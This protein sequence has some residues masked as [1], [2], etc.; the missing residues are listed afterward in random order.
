MNLFI[1]LFIIFSLPLFSAI[2]PSGQWSYRKAS[3]KNY[4]GQQDRVKITRSRVGIKSSF[5]A[6]KY[7]VINDSNVKITSQRELLKEKKT[8]ELIAQLKSLIARRGQQRQVGELKMRLAELY[9]EQAELVAAREGNQWNK[10]ILSWEKLSPQQRARYPRPKLSTPQAD[11]L[12]Q[13]SLVLYT[14]LEANS[15]GRDQGRSKLIRRDEVMF[16]L[17][18]TLKK[19]KQAPTAKRYLQELVTKFPNSARRYQG[20]MLLADI[21]FDNR[22]YKQAIPHYL[23]IA[24]SSRLGSQLQHLKPYSFYKLAWSYFNTGSYKKAVLAFKKTIS[25]STMAQGERKISFKKEAQNDLIKAF[26]LAGDYKNGESY[27]RSMGDK[28]LLGQYYRVAGDHARDQGRVDI[29]RNF[30]QKLINN[31]PNS[32]ESRDVSL[33][34]LQITQRQGGVAYLKA[35]D[36]FAKNYGANSRWYK[37][38]PAKDRKYFSEELANL[39][40][41]ETKFY[42]NL[43]QKKQSPQLMTQAEQFYKLY[44][45]YVPRPNPDTA[46]NVHE[47]RFFFAELLYEQKKYREAIPVYSSVGKGKYQN[48]ALYANVLAYQQLAEKNKGYAKG[49]Y[50]SV[51]GFQKS[52]PLDAKVPELL[53][54]SAYIFFQGKDYNSALSGLNEVVQKYPSH[55]RALESAERILFILEK[56]NRVQDVAKYANAFNNNPVLLNAGGQK[57]RSRLTDIQTKSSFKSVEILSEKSK[58]DL[59]KKAF[60]YFELSKRSTGELKIKA[61]NNAQ[62]LAE[63]SGRWDLEEKVN[64][65]LLAVAPNS[66]YSESIYRK[67]ADKYLANGNWRQALGLFERLNQSYPSSAQAENI[68]WNIIYIRS[69]LDRVWEPSLRP[70]FQMS[71]ALK[72][73]VENFIKKYPTS[74]RRTLAVKILANRAGASS[75]SVTSI[76]SFGRM[77]S[78]QTQ[79]ITYGKIAA[80]VR[81]GNLLSVAQYSPN[82]GYPYYV[83]EALGEAKFKSLESSYASFTNRKI[84]YTPEQFVSSIESKIAE[85]ERIEAQYMNVV[86]FGHGEWALR[87]LQRL[88]DLYSNIATDILK[89]PDVPAEELK[90]LTSPLQQKSVALL[91]TCLT[92]AA[93]IKITGPALLECRRKLGRI[94]YSYLPFTS[95]LLVDPQWLPQHKVK[96]PSFIF[97]SALKSYK[98]K[99]RGAFDL[100]LDWL[101]QNNGS[102]EEIQYLSVLKGV[103]YYAEGNLLAAENMWK[104][105]QSSNIPSIRSAAVRNLASLN[106]QVGD[107]N[108][109]LRT[110]GPYGKDEAMAII[111]GLSSHAKKQYK[112]ALSYYKKAISKN[113]NSALAYYNKAFTEAAMGQKKAGVKSM[114]K[115]IALTRVSSSHPAYQFINTWSR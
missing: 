41:K 31:A 71:S 4:L 22:N 33:D 69:H 6:N 46:A 63:R 52:F 20:E 21:N 14:E 32:I 112:Q 89:A 37:S 88:S 15:R 70:K 53:Y 84:I 17:G 93:E 103:M 76:Q 40:R 10:K 28:K 62:V 58:E 57:L 30:Y 109:A 48:P 87:S 72:F 11:Y 92:K 44:L 83:K 101:K 19:L 12:R 59:A 90:P 79:E 78:A 25:T 9:F 35:L 42:H 77:N 61:L 73:H 94:N 99:D 8:A 66:K 36:Q 85:L 98:S 80:S 97:V 114:K 82:A 107:F 47:M 24:G 113:K 23:R 106:L 115:Y 74:P 65:Q 49:F 67:K 13:K 29:A 100:S 91:R 34:F 110:A 55:P 5:Q 56:Q 16:F 86:A 50:K 7:A 26:A 39:L 60:A 1:K 104:Q 38:Q 18:A 27:F 95:Q 75:S 3:K 51:K 111:S 54:S 102:K 2:K 96:K 81:N 45:K 68:L 108:T 43:A 105:S 64:N